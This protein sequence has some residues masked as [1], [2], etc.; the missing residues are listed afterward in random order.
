MSWQ[1]LAQCEG[2]AEVCL[3]ESTQESAL[4][5]A[6]VIPDNANATSLEVTPL[7]ETTTDTYTEEQAALVAG[8]TRDLKR[9][10]L[11]RPLGNNAHEKI[12]RLREIQ[13][14][15]DYAVNGE[16]Y[17]ARILVLLGRQAVKRGDLNLASK[18]LLKALKF[19][20]KVRRQAEL[21]KAIADG[22]RKRETKL[23]TDQQKSENGKV[24]SYLPST[25]SEN[26]APQATDAGKFVAPVMVAIPAGNYLMG[27]D[28]GAEDEKPLH[29]VT[30]E[31]FSMSKHE[32]TMQQYRV[33]AIANGLPAPQFAE[34]QGNLPATHISW[35]DAKAYAAWL[36]EIIQR[37][38]RLPT[39]SEWEYAA[40]AGTATP[41]FS[42]ESL[43]D[44]AN[45]VGCGGQ[46]AGK[47]TAPVGS[48]APN[49][50]GLY[51]MHGNVWEWV[52]DCWTDNYNGRTKSAA[53]V[54]FDDCER[55]VLRGGSWYNDADYA[56][57][58]YR[59]NETP[60]FRDG[61]VGFRVV[62]DGL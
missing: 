53:A 49:E 28:T 39:E 16:K 20:P 43:T 35:H 1:V 48:F 2:G 4:P 21:K 41:F 24:T 25:E 15:H 50:F 14:N 27:S 7:D 54:Q 51:D 26:K 6:D 62:H 45:C 61:G 56:R 37:P 9:R 42:G 3:Q 46:W 13:P 47:S 36:G 5:I 11:T 33:F 32:I 38:Y 18:H 12:V 52:E 58:S 57:S 19:D 34:G 40:R 55:R 60:V 17:I 23:Q 22:A 31:A 29:H 8:I 44:A 59:G 10:S 30:I